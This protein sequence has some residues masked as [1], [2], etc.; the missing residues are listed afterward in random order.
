MS[1]ILDDSHG[2]KPL[3]HDV[4]GLRQVYVDKLFVLF[5]KIVKSENKVIFWDFMILFLTGKKKIRSLSEIYSS[6]SLVFSFS[7]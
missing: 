3:R 5:F 6:K 1:E 7:S 2:F 4:K